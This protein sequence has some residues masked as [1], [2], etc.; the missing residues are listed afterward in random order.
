MRQTLLE[1]ITEYGLCNP[2]QKDGKPLL[3][4]KVD[5][6]DNI[7]VGYAWAEHIPC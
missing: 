1:K 7:E 4:I 2:G 5:K 6:H 3:R